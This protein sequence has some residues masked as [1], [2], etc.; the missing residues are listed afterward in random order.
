MHGIFNIRERW[1][2]FWNRGIFYTGMST[3]GRSESSNNFFNCWL[4]PS[5]DLYSFI[6]KYAT[7]LLDTFEREKEEN[8]QSQLRYRIDN[9]V[10]EILVKSHSRPP[11]SFE[12]KIDLAGLTGH[13]ECKLFDYVGLPCRHLFRVFSKYDV[14]QILDAFIQPRWKID[15][16]KYSRSY[17]ESFLDGE[18]L[19]KSLHHNHLS[20]RASNL[21]EMASKNKTNFEYALLRLDGLKLHLDVY[22]ESLSQISGSDLSMSTPLT[23]I[24][25]STAPILDPLMAQTKGRTKDDHKEGGQWK[26]K[27]EITVEKKKTCKGCEVFGSHNKQTCPQLKL[28]FQK[29]KLGLAQMMEEMHNQ[30]TMV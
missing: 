14:L 28:L 5:I 2:P 13:C 17:D 24:V 25:M 18:N 6:A 4:L 3:S 23:E 27:M 26:G 19:R 22:D 30:T 21:F 29:Q 20:L 9:N 10:R 11:K 7:A 16:N 12:L 15:I 8:F 1:I